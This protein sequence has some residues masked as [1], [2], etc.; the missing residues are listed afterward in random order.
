MT[1]KVWLI[2]LAVFL[3]LLS[4]CASEPVPNEQEP[5]TQ[6]EPVD[7]IESPSP[8]LS[9][10]SEEEITVLSKMVWGEARG[11]PSDTEK[12]ACVWC[13]LNRVDYGYGNIV[14]VVTAP[15]QFAGYD[16]DNPIDDEIKAL[17]EDVLTRWYAE[18]A[19]ETDVGRVLPSD[20]MWFTGDGEHNY[21][22]NA[23]ERGKTWDWSLQSPYK[24]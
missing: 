6:A 20:Y 24:S 12:A 19:G 9:L 1:N 5:P 3:L 4:S 7:Q 22:R 15:Y 2:F 16:I 21:F 13:V 17:C 18:K 8:S 14:M 11:I 23:Y 10:W